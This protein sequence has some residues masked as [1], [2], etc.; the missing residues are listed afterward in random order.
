MNSIANYGS[1]SDG[2]DTE[3]SEQ[4]S[5]KNAAA[6]FSKSLVISSV[7]RPSDSSSNPPR[8]KVQIFVNVPQMEQ[9]TEVKSVHVKATGGLFSMLPEPKKHHHQDDE[10]EK[11]SLGHASDGIN[12]R[13]SI[14]KP[15]QKP[16]P[17]SAVIASQ[18]TKTP[19]P[20]LQPVE[21]VPDEEEEE[22]YF[23][24]GA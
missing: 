23:S 19:A 10:T 11:R 5:F 22:C 6:L 18:E 8:K 4:N 13:I 24:F 1:S 21:S 2:S 12:A 7:K 3:P 15:K 14:P 20:I 9:E 16:V 17:V